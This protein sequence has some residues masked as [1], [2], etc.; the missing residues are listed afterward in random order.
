MYVS[1]W[2]AA[3]PQRLYVHADIT[4]CPLFRESDILKRTFTADNGTKDI[5]FKW[6]IYSFWYNKSSQAEFSSNSPRM[7][8]CS[9]QNG[10]SFSLCSWQ[11]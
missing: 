6:L 11:I 1:I 10:S 9:R 5:V 7:E 4:R 3:T 2:P 8:T